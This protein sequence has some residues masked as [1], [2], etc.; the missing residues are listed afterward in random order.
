MISD[1]IM[2]C[3]LPQTLP[4]ELLSC[5]IRDKIILTGIIIQTLGNKNSYYVIYGSSMRW[6]SSWYQ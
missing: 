6:L 5:V 3:C 2:K 1:Q 4:L